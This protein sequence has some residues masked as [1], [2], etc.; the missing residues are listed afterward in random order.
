MS[1]FLSRFLCFAAAT[2]SS[3]ESAP[4]VSYAEAARQAANWIVAT[5]LP[6]PSGIGVYWPP[7][8]VGQNAD[9]SYN[10]TFDL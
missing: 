10:R 5:A 9:A 3:V 1:R 6:A 2:L 8:L 7:D 4:N